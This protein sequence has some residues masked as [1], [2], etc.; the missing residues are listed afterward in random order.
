MGRA[1]PGSAS[2]PGANKG[3]KLQE[4][5]L[6]YDRMT[7]KRS[8]HPLGCSVSPLQHLQLD[9]NCDIKEESS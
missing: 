7:R 3:Q 8:R 5:P 1:D 4:V 2:M 9:G 6:N